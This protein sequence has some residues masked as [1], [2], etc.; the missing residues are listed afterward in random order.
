MP[1]RTRSGEEIRVELALTDLHSSR[2]ERFAVAIARDAAR[3]KQLELTS[4]ELV[5]SQIARSDLETALAGRDE[6]LDALLATLS[7]EPKTDELRRL[8]AVIADIRQLHRGELKTRSNDADL[9]DL[10]HTAAD[11]ARRRA[12][13][14]RILVHAP[15]TAPATVDTARMRQILDLVLDAAIRA[16]PNAG[17]IEIRLERVPGHL[18][19][20]SVRTD[21]SSQLHP[22]GP[23]LLLAR[24]LMQRQGGSLSWNVSSGGALEVMVTLPASAGPVRV[25]S[26]RPARRLSNPPC[27]R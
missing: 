8:V 18:E 5:Q 13:A 2:G 10:V 16:C 24:G 19:Q 20:L 12:S 6:L 27:F 3:R 15:P 21:A 4:L 25:R 11:A 23:G 1:A 9:V 14:R 7:E 17:R 26:I 22:A